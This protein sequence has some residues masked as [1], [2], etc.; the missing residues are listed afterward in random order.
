MKMTSTNISYILARLTMLTQCVILEMKLCTFL[1]INPNSS[2]TYNLD[3][4]I[5]S[6]EEDMGHGA[7]ILSDGGGTPSDLDEFIC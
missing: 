2:V 5:N 4:F 7:H 6:F 1:S 3:V